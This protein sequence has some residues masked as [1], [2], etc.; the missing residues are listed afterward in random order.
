MEAEKEPF[1]GLENDKDSFNS[2]SKYGYPRETPPHRRMRY[3]I[4]S[5]LI[6]CSVLSTIL[7]SVYFFGSIGSV[8]EQPGVGGSGPFLYCR[9]TILGIDVPAHNTCSSSQGRHWV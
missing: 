1:L 4:F 3:W 9:S 8:N 6:H 7:G 5:L 2:R